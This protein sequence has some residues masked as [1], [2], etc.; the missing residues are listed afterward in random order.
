MNQAQNQV[1]L[2]DWLDHQKM[3][4]FQ[5]RTI[6]LCFLVT[7]FD[8]FDTQAI[9]FTGPAIQ[10]SL[11]INASA[12]APIVSAG[13]AGMA[14]GALL[15]GPVGDIWG[16]RFA[17]I[18]AT[19]LFGLFS[20]ATA[21]ADS[22]GYLM[23]FRF[24]TGIGMGGATP[25]VLALASEYSPAKL[26]GVLMLVATLGLAGGAIIGSIIAAIIIPQAGWQSVYLIG[27]IA[28]LVFIP[29]L[30]RLFPESPYYLAQKGENGAVDKILKAISWKNC[31]PEGSQY[32]LPEKSSSIA[33]AQLFAP[34]IRRNTFAI[35]LVYFFNWIAWFM[36]LLW[37]PT[38]LRAAGL[39][40][41]Q[42]ALGTATVN[43]AALLFLIP[44]AIYLPKIQVKSLIIGLL[45]GGV[46]VCFGLSMVGNN[47]AWVFILVGLSGLTIGGPQLAL[48]YLAVQ[49]YPT[50]ARATG[51]G[52]AIGIGRVGTII[53]AYIGGP[54]LD[55]GGAEGFYL[56]LINPLLV[57]VLAALLV[58][59]AKQKLAENS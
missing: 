27:G 30:L 6:F 9:A 52:W 34:E 18:L 13:V 37:L 43:G 3:S 45:F 25:N 48:N 36:L 46:L 31:P 4:S 55:G 58:R 8:G 56:Y 39:T 12:L 32:L 50:S 17:V 10:E 41:E 21:Y 42:S 26:R 57:A 47:L 24:L 7:T 16:R 53:G 5:W 49:I 28:P 40:M 20:L 15:L 33:I 22:I 54:I 44:L 14:V 51:V 38:A 11:G 59:T 29:V 2:S 23:L 19:G 35:W 1:V